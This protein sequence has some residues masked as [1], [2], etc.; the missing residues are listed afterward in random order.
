MK[1]IIIKFSGRRHIKAKVTLNKNQ[2]EYRFN[3]LVQFLGNLCKEI[4]WEIR[5]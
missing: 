2:Y 1:D 5:D 3:G 4:N